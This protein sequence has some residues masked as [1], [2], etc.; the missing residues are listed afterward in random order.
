MLDTRKFGDQLKKAG[1]DFYSGVPCSFLKDLINYAINDCEYVMA[2][3]EGD[4]VAVCAGAYL[5]GRRSVVLMQNSGLGNA[6]SPLTSLNA[7]FG[8]PVLGFV[9]LRGEQ[10]IPD[11]PQ[12]G[13]MGLITERMLEVM[14]I[15]YAVLSSDQAEA[16]QQLSAAAETIDSGKPFFFIVRKGTFSAVELAEDKK[17]VSRDDLG[18][19]YEMLK[20][21][22]AGAP[23]DALFL[24]TT[25]FTGRELYQL[26]DEPN[27]L[28][29]VGSL[30]CVSSLGLGVSLSRPDKPVIVL[31]GD[32]SLLMRAG[33]L[34]VNAWY[35]PRR[36][37]H[38]LFDNRVH[39]STGCQFTVSPGINYPMLAEAFGYP[40]VLQ[41]TDPAALEQAVRLWSAEGGLRFIHVPIAAGAPENLGRPKIT[42]R[43]VAERFR[44]F[45]N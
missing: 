33:S 24:A 43:E 4:A 38:I 2:A 6:V 22:K 23:E 45:I 34:G 8:I 25:G 20:R 9:S 13:L 39:E 12:H 44:K 32:G 21:V 10:G 31:D 26:G 27:N 3:N 7:V 16:E 40:S 11:E 5:G 41:T 42:P 19:R 17:P 18:T 35:K 29:M 28:Y 36:M 15:D 37:L 30:G 14:G 1:F